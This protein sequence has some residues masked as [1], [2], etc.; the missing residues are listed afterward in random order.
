MIRRMCDFFTTI[1]VAGILYSGCLTQADAQNATCATRPTGDNSNACA[2]TA[3]VNNTLAAGIPLPR[4]NI[5]VGNSSNI[6]TATTPKASAT[7][8]ATAYGVLCDAST[9]DLAA[10]IAADT[11]ASTAGA[12]LVFPAGT[13]VVSGTLTPSAGAH[14]IG[15]STTKTSLVTTSATADLVV[16]SNAGITIEYISYASFPTRTAGA[17]V[18]VTSFGL[19]MLHTFMTGAFTGLLLGTSATTVLVDDLQSFAAVAATGND[20]VVNG[21]SDCMFRNITLSNS[22]VAAPFSHI[23]LLNAGNFDCFN[24]NLLLGL[25]NVYI[26]PTTGQGVFS[27]NFVGGYLDQGQAHNLQVSPSGTGVFARSKFIGVW[28]SG[29]PA[30]SASANIL[31]NPAS[32]ATVDGI[33]F[34]DIE[35]YGSVSQ[36]LF[37]Y[38]FNGTTTALTN[39][40]ING[41]KIANNGTGISSNGM[42]NLYLNGVKI[43]P[44][45]AFVGNGTGMNLSGTITKVMVNGTDMSGNTVTALT[46]TASITTLLVRSS[47][48]TAINTAIAVAEGGTNCTAASGACLDNITGFAGTGFLTRTGA[49]AYAFQSTT[50]GITLGNLAQIGANTMLGNWTSGTANV[51]ANA[52]P[53]CSAAQSALNYTT[54]TGI[55]CNS[56]L[57]ALPSNNAFTGVN[58]FTVSNSGTAMNAAATVSETR[59]TTVGT[60]GIF[61]SLQLNISDNGTT[62]AT[63]LQSFR[64]AYANSN[65]GDVGSAAFDSGATISSTFN[66][67]LASQ[68]RALDVNGP[69]VA[70]GKTV[71]I[72]HGMYVSAKSGAGA[73]T[74]LRAI[75]TEAGAGTV[76]IGDTTAATSSTTGSVTT[77]GG[78]SA[79]GAIWAGTY[80]ATTT[81]AVASLPSCGAG[82][83]GA[84]MFVTDNNTALAFAAVITT[85]GAIQTPVYC[86]GTVWRQG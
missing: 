39:I 2:S 59:T 45:S 58:T 65:T 86:D 13:C 54:N 34:T 51:A 9:D 16:I 49:G 75:T 27:V 81:T 14:W 80:V 72:W 30:A 55:G 8:Y 22:A 29:T 85:G 52:M 19:T 36:S 12:A 23:Q 11:A 64:L 46:N 53:S 61:S 74:V 66:N 31:F 10:I 69:V 32:T 71:G 83:K 38:Q 44:A 17:F 62:A 56:T 40:T 84:R 82:I 79:G 33:D 4:A 15:S 24:C 7:L 26:A 1:L 67:S 68:F 77:A 47:L 73:V 43:G 70:S 48:P 35:V 78:F 6:A 41:G 37:G 57:A 63:S 25:I 5:F 21:C 18:N 60:G 20:I 3:F 42:G 76:N 28:M 50:N